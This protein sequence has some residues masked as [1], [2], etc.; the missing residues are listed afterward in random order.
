MTQ[1][2]GG[3]N[4]LGCNIQETHLEINSTLLKKM[5]SLASDRR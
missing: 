4:N 1:F 3:Y 2:G 5:N